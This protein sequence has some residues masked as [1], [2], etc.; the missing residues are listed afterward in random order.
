MWFKQII[1]FFGFN[2]DD[3]FLVTQPIVARKLYIAPKSE[4]VNQQSFTSDS[5][6]DLLDENSEP[7][8]FNKK[9]GVY[10]ISRVGLKDFLGQIAGETY[11]EKYL[12]TLDV[13]IVHPETLS[14][15]KQIEL[16]KNAKMLIFADGSAYHTLQLLGHVNCDVLILKRRKL[17]GG[18][19]WIKNTLNPRCNTLKFSDFG[20]NIISGLA[21]F[22][23]E[24]KDKNEMLIK[25]TEDL[26]ICIYEQELFS[27]IESWLEK[28]G[29]SFKKVKFNML[30]Y[31]ESVLKDYENHLKRECLKV[32]ER[33]D[34]LNAVK[35]C[36]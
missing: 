21:P 6:L 14:I 22:P 1:T 10:Y 29:H 30:E 13:N 9:Q 25:L 7:V 16:Y 11:L 33:Y 32:Q 8:P 36:N 20:G 24:D 12:K 17:D 27:G 3:V 31:F 2:A 23:I 18:D 15:Q 26:A 34:Y 35:K 19:M 4:W 5:Y 28:F